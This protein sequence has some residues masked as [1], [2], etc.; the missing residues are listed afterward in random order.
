MQKKN[1]L[2][3]DDD[4][5]FRGE[6]SRTLGGVYGVEVAESVS[7]FE[8]AYKPYSYDL[9]IIDM[10]LE[11]GRE[12]LDLLRS[13]MAN[14][15]LQPVIIVT[16]YPDTES[17]IEAIHAGALMF[18]NKAE[19]SPPLLAKMVEAIVTQAVLQKRIASLE[20][21]LDQL[22][23]ADII[24]ASQLLREMKSQIQKAAADGE[25]TV[26]IRGESGTGKELVARNIHKLSSKRNRGP[27]I[28]VSMAGLHRE[29]MHSDLF[30]HEK[31]SFTGA[32]STRKGFLEEAHGGT[33]FLDEMGDLDPAAQIKLL[34]VLETRRFQR[35]GGNREV[36]IDVQIVAATH[37]DLEERMQS[38]SFREDLYYRL[39]AFEIFVP[40][41][42]RRADDI[43]P[44]SQHFLK[45][46]LS[47]SRTSVDSFAPEVLPA[48]QQYSWPGNVR[49]LRN[50][51]EF[52]AIQARHDE[53]PRIGLQHLPR[54][55]FGA[56]EPRSF[57]RSQG[58]QDNLAWAE[59]SL[60]AREIQQSKTTKQSELAR[61][62]QYHDRFTFSR[63]LRRILSRHPQFADEF[64][65]VAALF[66]EEM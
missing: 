20:R 35:L 33:L 2:L 29:T 16:S 59:I 58:Y 34:R 50:V 17:Y 51:V 5:K 44:L 9:V 4:S 49:E 3:V 56:G 30:G 10:R 46:M 25:V 62:L 64:P 24:G 27:F 13:I 61:N 32:V 48:F 39:K 8:R 63:R 65:M 60:V 54:H 28:A 53:S 1:V 26:L 42:Y 43:I 66:R 11:S 14:D 52:A 21:R 19:F 22:E 23:P 57:H 31:G 47:E 41:L 18:L 37:Q 12:G 15:P 55:L 38:G 6:V 45:G 7:Q 36:L 40:P